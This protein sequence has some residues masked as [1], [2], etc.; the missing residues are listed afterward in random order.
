MDDGDAM[1][2]GGGNDGSRSPLFQKLVPRFTQ[3]LQKVGLSGGLRQ[4]LF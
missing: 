2:G 4:N 1:G 3:K